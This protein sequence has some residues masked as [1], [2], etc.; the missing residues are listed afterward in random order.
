DSMSP[1]VKHQHLAG[2]GR[3]RSPAVVVGDG[4]GRRPGN[5]GG[6]PPVGLGRSN[7]TGEARPEH[8]H[9]DQAG[10]PQNSSHSSPAK[11]RTS[12]RQNRSSSSMTSWISEE[13]TTS[14]VVSWAA[15]PAP[16]M[17]T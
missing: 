4:G 8:H 3:F 1:R 12:S 16:S 10:V 17:A 13:A 6:L 7:S 15:V 11:R 9:A 14:R 2:G 5:V